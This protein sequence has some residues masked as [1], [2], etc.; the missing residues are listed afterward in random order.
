[1]RQDKT[2]TMDYNDTFLVDGNEFNRFKNVSKA[3]DVDIKIQAM[4]YLMFK[5]GK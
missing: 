4:S 3:E 2:K 1:M 5:I